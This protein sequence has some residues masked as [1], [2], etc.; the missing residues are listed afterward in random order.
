MTCIGPIPEHLRQYAWYAPHQ[1]WLRDRKCYHHDP[2]NASA[3]RADLRGADLIRANLRGANLRGA[4]L[5]Y[6]NLSGAD[7]TEANLSR[8]SAEWAN[9]TQANLSR[10]SAEWANLRGADLTYADLS[11]ADLTEANLSGADLIGADLTY[12]NLSGAN[13]TYANLSRADLTEANLSRAN[14]RGA[15]ITGAI[16]PTP[17]PDPRTLEEAVALTK[18]W[19]TPERWIQ[20]R[21]IETPDGWG[22]GSCRACLHGAVVYTGGKFSREMSGRLDNNGYTQAWNDVQERTY[23]EVIAALDA[24]TD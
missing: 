20:H 24:I 13:L 19:L 9:L 4:N 12:A 3:E 18:Q 21:W 22:A 10:A 23:N 17:G 15:D 11:G 8:A 6:A 2:I 5:T 14:L 7:L 16:L 1:A